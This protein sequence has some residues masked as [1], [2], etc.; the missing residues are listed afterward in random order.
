VPIFIHGPLVFPSAIGKLHITGELEAVNNGCPYI[1]MHVRG[2]HEHL[3]LD[4]VA[5]IREPETW[6]N[7]AV[8]AAGLG[9]WVITGGSAMISTAAL[10]T[11]IGP[12]AILWFMVSND[13]NVV[14]IPTQCK[15]LFSIH[16][17]ACRQNQAFT[18]AGQSTALNREMNGLVLAA[19]RIAF[20]STCHGCPTE[21]RSE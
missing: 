8:V 12:V 19:L 17:L 13:S 4:T 21:G 5:N 2:A 10:S 16:Q 20:C 9:A 15:W 14:R 7:A 3:T 1:W 6:K 11:V 18:C